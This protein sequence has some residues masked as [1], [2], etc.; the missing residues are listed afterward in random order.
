[1][2][3]FATRD[4]AT[5]LLLLAVVSL[6]PSQLV[7]LLRTPT[8]PSPSNSL[9]EAITGFFCDGIGYRSSLHVGRSELHSSRLNLSS[10]LLASE[11][12][13]R[14]QIQN[15]LV[16]VMFKS[17]NAH[18]QLERLVREADS[19]VSF[20]AALKPLLG[21]LLNVYPQMPYG[22]LYHTELSQ[23]LNFKRGDRERSL[24]AFR[25]GVQGGAGD[26]CEGAGGRSSTRCGAYM[27]SLKTTFI[28]VNAEGDQRVKEPHAYC[29]S[30]FAT[31]LA[32][33]MASQGIQF[34]DVLTGA[35]IRWDA[36][37]SCVVAPNGLPMWIVALQS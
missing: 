30:L 5:T 35:L 33:L 7:L 12:C 27:S 20:E 26:P 13:D 15:A 24:I 8:H 37:H 29:S 31:H 3:Q 32:P 1:M 28:L 36:Q 18:Q 19:D 6:Q 16:W 9:Q 21:R 2:L 23:I 10:I 25:G 34:L 17:L 22:T 14:T 4:R 11:R